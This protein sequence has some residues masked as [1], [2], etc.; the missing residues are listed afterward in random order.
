MLIWYDV[1][2]E[3]A[4]KV[5]STLEEHGDRPFDNFRR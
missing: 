2:L 3:R 1:V 5:V 4:E